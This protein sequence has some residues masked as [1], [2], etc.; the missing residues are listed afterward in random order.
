MYNNWFIAYWCIEIIS[1]HMH[2]WSRIFTP[3]QI[4]PEQ[5]NGTIGIFTLI[6][7]GTVQIP[8]YRLNGRIYNKDYNRI[9]KTVS[10]YHIIRLF[11]ICFA[12]YMYIC[13][14]YFIYVYFTL[15]YVYF[16]IYYM[17]I[18]LTLLV[19]VRYDGIEHSK[20]YWR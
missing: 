16:I 6:L 12:I 18:L 7:H 19:L 2:I 15:L 4:G 10:K 1:P 14:F 11:I 20:C 17:Y 8:V 9:H 3:F 5:N 13:I